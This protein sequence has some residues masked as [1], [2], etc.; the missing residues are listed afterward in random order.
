MLLAPG[1]TRVFPRPPR[2]SSRDLTSGP[3]ARSG[4]WL[5][6]LLVAAVV[7]PAAGQETGGTRPDTAA[8][9]MVT[10]RPDFT[11]SA[12][13]VRRAQLEVGWTVATAGGGDRHRLGEALVRI[14]AVS[15]LELRVGL[16]S[17]TGDGRPGAADGFGDASVGVKLE[18]AGGAAGSGDGGRLAVLAGTRFPV[19]DRGSEGPRPE[20]RLAGALPL[21]PRLA[22][23]A[24]LGAAAAEDGAG[25]FA[26]ALASA[27]LGWEVGGP[28]GLFLEAYGIARSDGRADEA[29]VDGGVTL[30]LSPDL[31][32]DAR[33]GVPVH[34]GGRD[35]E[36][37]AGL[38][39]RF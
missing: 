7:V 21:A 3:P 37:G 6:V 35:L 8:A 17:W 36:A 11:E 34:R 33:V 27:A 16:P 39:V 38:S 2:R 31:Q 23:G 32:L 29:V 19:G 12:V 28:W 20:A 4:W 25:R 24:N 5:A 30:R 13:A 10:D 18:L 1:A 15:G 26:E 14:P 9:P 22:L